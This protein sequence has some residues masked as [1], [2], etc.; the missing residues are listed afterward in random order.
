TGDHAAIDWDG[1][2][3]GAPVPDGRYDVEVRAQD[4]WEN[5]PTTKT[6]HL[7]IDTVGPELA[8]LTEDTDP[9]R[10][11]SPN[12]DAYRDDTTWTASTAEPG[13]VIMG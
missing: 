10:W 2:D 4:A 1:L 8:S 12:G 11:F 7:T 6:A 13:T 5:G 9:A 3:G